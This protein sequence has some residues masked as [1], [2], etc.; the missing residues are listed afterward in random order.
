MAE[1]STPISFINHES[2]LSNKDHSPD[3][4]QNEDFEQRVLEICEELSQGDGVTIE[5]KKSF[6]PRSAGQKDFD[7]LIEQYNEHPLDEVEEELDETFE[8]ISQSNH[9]SEERKSLFPLSLTCKEDI[10]NLYEEEDALL[11]KSLERIEEADDESA[12]TTML[13]SKVSC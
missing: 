5:E 10:S 13:N 11:Q 1:E 12:L 6:S 9:D 3:T 7:Y 8:S 4:P 2:P